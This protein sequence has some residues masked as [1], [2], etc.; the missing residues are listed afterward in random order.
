MPERRAAVRAALAARRK[1]RDAEA[2]A[3]EQAAELRARAASVLVTR[4]D[5]LGGGNCAVGTED[6]IA[7]LERML[8]R[9]W[10]GLRRLKALRGDTLLA[11]RD[12]VY[13]RRA[14]SVAVERT[15]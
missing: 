14:V 10:P 8:R 12:D 4:E 2:R 3:A 1:Q 7:R 6:G 11:L 9:S 15:S 5:S 13:T